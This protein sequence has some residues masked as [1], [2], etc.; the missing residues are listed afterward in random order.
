MF[1]TV[2]W[3]ADASAAVPSGVGAAVGAGRRPAVGSDADACKTGGT[4]AV[5]T[6]L[7]VKLALYESVDRLYKGRLSVYIKQ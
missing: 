2:T 3:L 4:D 6:C 7:K 1:S 5:T